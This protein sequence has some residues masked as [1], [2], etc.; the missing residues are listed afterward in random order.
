MGT[1]QKVSES[2]LKIKRRRHPVGRL[3][4]HIKDGMKATYTAFFLEYNERGLPR[5]GKASI[6]P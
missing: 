2:G 1:V 5:V 4:A 3:G 6:R